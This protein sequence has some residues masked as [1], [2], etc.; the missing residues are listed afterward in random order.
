MENLEDILN[1]NLK[2]FDN[3]NNIKII[4][5][6][7]N[8]EV[9]RCY[10]YF[11]KNDLHEKPYALLEDVFIEENYRNR[12]YGKILVKKAIEIA[13]QKGCYKIIATSRFEREN[14]HK[15]YE[16]LGFK[17]WGYEFRIDL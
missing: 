14:V 10:L 11:I 8:K 16:K 5:E 6:I 12:G 17:K 4:L 3:G 1:K 15:F 2:I 13:K 9:G 7:E